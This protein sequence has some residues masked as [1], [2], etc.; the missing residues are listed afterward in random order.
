MDGPELARRLQEK[1]PQLCFL[2]TS[3]YNLGLMA[4]DRVLDDDVAFIA[5]P[6]TR[7]QLAEKVREALKSV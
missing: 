2:F 3:G 5:K 4:P 6:F 1:L 7:S